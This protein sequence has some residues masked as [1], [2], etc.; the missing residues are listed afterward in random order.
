[1]APSYRH[2]SVS[3]LLAQII[4]VL[5]EEL[6]MPFIAAGRTTFKRENLEKGLEP[7]DCFYFKSS[8]LIVGKTELDLTQDPPPDL[9][10]EVVSPGDSADEIERKIDLYLSHGSSRVWVVYTTSRRIQVRQSSGIS[11]LGEDSL[12]DAPEIFPGWS[13]RVSDLLV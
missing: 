13:V 4:V 12:I 5:A 2:E 9:A 6:E 11:M 10:I 8:P 3:F 1:M 7:E